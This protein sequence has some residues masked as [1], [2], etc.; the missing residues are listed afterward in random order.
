MS[1]RIFLILLFSMGTAHAEEIKTDYFSI[2][3]PDPLLVE[4]GPGRILVSGPNG[5]YEPPL[6]FISIEYVGNAE[7]GLEMLIEDANHTLG[8]A[9]VGT[10]VEQVD[11]ANNCAAY[12]GSVEQS[13]SAMKVNSYF[14]VIRGNNISAAISAGFEGDYDGAKNLLD[15]VA[16]QIMAGR[17]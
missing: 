11:C 3:F 8:Q 14:Y 16:G 4:A 17:I 5:P 9:K 12:F 2:I 1:I 10:V 13:E 6:Q 15:D 7:V